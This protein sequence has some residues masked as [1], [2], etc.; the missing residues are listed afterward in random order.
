[1]LLEAETEEVF[2][3]KVWADIWDVLDSS[4]GGDTDYSD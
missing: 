2:L 1:M 4:F 3:K